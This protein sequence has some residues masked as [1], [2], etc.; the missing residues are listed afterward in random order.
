MVVASLVV[1]ATPGKIR[2]A[3]EEMASVHGITVHNY[4]GCRII[5]TAQMPDGCSIE[6]IS[7]PLLRIDGVVDVT[8]IYL[9]EFDS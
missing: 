3:A 6:S 7:E 8:L 4:E 1:E 2:S 9:E 5:V